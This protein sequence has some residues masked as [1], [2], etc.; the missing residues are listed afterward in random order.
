MFV[1]FDNLVSYLFCE[2]DYKLL[3]YISAMHSSG[4]ANQ[5]EFVENSKARERKTDRQGEEEGEFWRTRNYQC[6]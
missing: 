3:H 4:R 5:L 1:N 6:D 2:Y